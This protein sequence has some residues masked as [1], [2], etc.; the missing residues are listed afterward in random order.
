[1]SLEDLVSHRG[2]G[3]EDYREVEDA[4]M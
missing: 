3:D 4:E 1:M 2:R